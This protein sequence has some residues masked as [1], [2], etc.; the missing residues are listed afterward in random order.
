MRRMEAALLRKDFPALDQTIYGKQLV[1]LDNA[2]TTQTP[3]QV[4]GAMSEYMAHS[5]SNVHRSV[6]YL[7]GEATRR[8][9]AARD[10]VAAFLNAEREEIVFTGGTTDAINLVA[11]ALEESI[12]PGD[13]VLTTDMEHHSNYL[14]WMNL[15]KKREA[16][17]QRIPL[18]QN[19]ALDLERAETQLRSG[20]VK[21][22]AFCQ[23]S[24]VTGI[25][26]PVAQLSALAKAEGVPVLI[27]GAQG[28]R[29]EAVDV[30]ALDC[31]FYCFSAH[32]LFGPTGIGV[33]YAKKDW[34][35]TWAP[36]RLG[37]GMIKAL[38][39]ERSLYEQPPLRF[40]AGT[41]NLVGAAGMSAAIK[42]LLQHNPAGLRERERLLTERLEHAVQEI[43]GVTI[44]GKS[45]AR[46]G[47]VS[48]VCE[49]ASSFDVALLL[50][51]LGIAVRSGHHCA[52][53]QLQ[54][55]GIKTA[56]RVSPAF[57]NTEAEIDHFATCLNKVLRILRC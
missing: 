53:P 46:R 47:M 49:G 37:G 43:E 25:L 9:E 28:V 1:Y 7:S 32:K 41:P 18:D 17:F 22:L 29:H 3:V 51:K 31:D 52:I 45:Q 2:A 19:G 44:L 34:L 56:V 20:R 13:A 6:H 21:L 54:H 42:Y 16:A 27:D 26:N 57:Y 23:V 55:L 4:I 48:F 10:A 36:V 39:D 24:N 40:E 50:D 14:P 5:H 35:D 33:L 38:S 15:C 8:Y 30:K 12:G 11:R